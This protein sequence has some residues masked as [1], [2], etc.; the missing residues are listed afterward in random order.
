MFE[1]VRFFFDPVRFF[2]RLHQ[3]QEFLAKP[4]SVLIISQRQVVLQ[5]CISD[6]KVQRPFID[7]L[8][9]DSLSSPSYSVMPSEENPR[10]AT[11]QTNGSDR[12]NDNNASD[13][14][15]LRQWRK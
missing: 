12:T 8:D 10:D 2:F 14:I 13:E 7:L 5:L 6:D 15:G 3:W 9:A 4:F 11:C 1:T